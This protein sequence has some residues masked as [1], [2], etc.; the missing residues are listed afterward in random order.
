MKKMTKCRA[1]SKSDEGSLSFYFTNSQLT[2]GYFER[3]SID[4]KPFFARIFL[5]VLT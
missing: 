2:P 5:I 3:R 1:S 4:T